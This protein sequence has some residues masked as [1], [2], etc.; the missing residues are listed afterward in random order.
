MKSLEERI[1]AIEA[2]NNRVEM[3]KKWEVSWT[4]RLSISALTYLVVVCYLI[5]VGNDHPFVNGIVPPVG[6]MLSTLIMRQVRTW[7]QKS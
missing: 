1:E 5:T 2:R 4:R 7:W 3:D 6:F